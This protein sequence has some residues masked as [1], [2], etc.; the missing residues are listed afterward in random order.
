MMPKQ[1]FSYTGL[2]LIFLVSCGVLWLRNRGLL[3]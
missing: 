3:P 2:L 1:H